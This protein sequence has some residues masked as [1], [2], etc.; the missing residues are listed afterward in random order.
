M[1]SDLDNARV[2]FAWKFTLVA[3]TKRQLAPPWA[4]STAVTT[5][6]AM[7]LKTS[8]PGND[9]WILVASTGGT[10]ASSG[11]GPTPTTGPLASLDGSVQWV[12]YRLS[13]C[14]Y[15]TIVNPGS[16]TAT[17]AGDVNLQIVPVPA[18]NGSAGP[19]FATPLAIYA[20]STG[21]PSLVAVVNQ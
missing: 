3:N 6:D 9:V 19:F 18:S 13:G 14:R 11:T 4:T 10:T 12:G 16:D 15:L 5:L 2:A 21:T 8:A 17:T 7:V 1:L 20:I